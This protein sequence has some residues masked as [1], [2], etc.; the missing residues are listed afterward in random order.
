MGKINQGFILFV[1]A[2][3]YAVFLFITQWNQIQYAPITLF[4]FVIIIGL[5]F[6]LDKYVTRKIYGEKWSF[7]YSLEQI[8]KK[9]N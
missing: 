3:A 8:I 4:G 2:I 9:T 5:A 6:L 1:G 7:T